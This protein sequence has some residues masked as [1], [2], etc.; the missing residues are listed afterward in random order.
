MG[1]ASPHLSIKGIS[2]N[3]E[4]STSH[5]TRAALYYTLNIGLFKR[6]VATREIKGL[7]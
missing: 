6:D 5:H 3:E 1:V 2:L 7:V 4:I